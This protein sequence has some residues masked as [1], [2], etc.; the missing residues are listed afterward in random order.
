MGAS[1][2]T[3]CPLM[4]VNQAQ[5]WD[6]GYCTRPV[7][8]ISGAEEEILRVPR[9]GHAEKL[10]KGV[11]LPG[12]YIPHKG[13]LERIEALSLGDTGNEVIVV[14][15]WE[16]FPESFREVATQP[17]RLLGVGEKEFEGAKYVVRSDIVVPVQRG[18][19]FTMARCANCLVF[20]ASV[21]PR[22]ILGL[23]FFARYGLVVLPHPGCFALVED[24]CQGGPWDE[25]DYKCPPPETRTPLDMAGSQVLERDVNEVEHDGQL[26]RPM[27]GSATMSCVDDKNFNAHEV[28]R[29][30][31]TVDISESLAQLQEL[32]ESSSCHDPLFGV[33][34]HECATCE[35]AEMNFFERGHNKPP[36]V[37][38]SVVEYS[39]PQVMDLIGIMLVGSLTALNCSVVL[40]VKSSRG[41]APSRWLSLK[42]I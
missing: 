28:H 26:C 2:V 11:I 40:P 8:R 4:W 24:L 32:Q 14:A 23:P 22:D 31:V 18:S 1:P 3:V 16:L 25:F 35:G 21:G 38:P 29:G 33:S 15:G 19:Q 6:D 12:I 17:F 36:K 37:C 13:I 20:L 9:P 34:S 27:Q 42:V 7:L 10:P 5:A 41:G 39:I 30:L